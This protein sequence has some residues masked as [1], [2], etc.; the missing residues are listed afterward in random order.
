MG[1]LCVTP[2][3]ESSTIPVNTKSS[4]LRSSPQTDLHWGGAVGDCRGPVL[5]VLGEEG[6]VGMSALTGGTARGIQGQHSLDGYIH[7][8][9]VEG[10][11][12]D[13]ERLKKKA[14]SQAE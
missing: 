4:Y 11:K 12:H 13:L 9:G 7:G 5:G 6:S 2:S 3:P 10:L 14:L 8:W 1:T